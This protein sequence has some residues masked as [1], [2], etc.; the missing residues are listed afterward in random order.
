MSP[1]TGPQPPACRATRCILSLALRRR[2]ARRNFQ[3]PPCARAFK[4]ILEYPLMII[5][6]TIIGFPNAGRSSRAL[7]WPLIYGGALVIL[8]CAI[9]STLIVIASRSILLANALTGFVLIG[10]YLL[11]LRPIR[12][13]IA[14]TTPLCAQHC[15]ARPKAASLNGTE[16]FRR[17][18]CRRRRPKT[19]PTPLPRHDRSRHSIP[20]PRAQLR[21][22]FLLSPPGARQ[23]NHRSP[24]KVESSDVGLVGLGAGAMLS[25]AQPDQTWTVFEIDPA[26]IRVAQRPN[27]SLT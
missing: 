2:C 21:P 10:C 4:S 8:V 14:I 18:A 9:A 13:A 6:A 25:Y 23:R 1:Q 22:Q 27:V 20:H 24:R 7:L 16:I 12:Y 19:A 3:R 15:F 5:V 26:V 17:S 11:V